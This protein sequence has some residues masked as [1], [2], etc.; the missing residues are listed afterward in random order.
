LD[1]RVSPS[2]CGIFGVWAI[3][4]YEN[5]LRA[6]S[7]KIFERRH[8]AERIPRAPPLLTEPPDPD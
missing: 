7:E 4:L 5:V 8:S 1:P 3:L 2:G 6:R